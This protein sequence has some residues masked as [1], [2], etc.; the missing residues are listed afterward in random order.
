MNCLI[1]KKRKLDIVKE[2]IETYNIVNNKID[3]INNKLIEVFK[4]KLPQVKLWRLL[5]DNK[6]NFKTRRRKFKFRSNNIKKN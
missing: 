3:D 1:I 2:I 5:P 6:F 4:S